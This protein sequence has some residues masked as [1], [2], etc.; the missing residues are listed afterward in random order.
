MA[1][2]TAQL[3]NPYPRE[4]LTFEPNRAL[5]ERATGVTGGGALDA[6]SALFDPGDETI[7]SHEEL[8]PKLLFLALGLFL[9]DLAL[10]RVR[11]FDRD[12]RRPVRKRR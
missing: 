10:R 6:I 2:S 11:L 1:E 7:R 5:L 4:Y 12:F 3:A 8:W 9:L